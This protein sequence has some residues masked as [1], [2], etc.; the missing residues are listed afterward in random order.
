MN[1][2]V[3]CDASKCSE[4]FWVTRWFLSVRFAG[5]LR[6]HRFAPEYAGAARQLKQTNQPIRLAK[7]GRGGVEG[8]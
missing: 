4:D 8:G 3:V 7:A 6:I 1:L 2:A 5:R